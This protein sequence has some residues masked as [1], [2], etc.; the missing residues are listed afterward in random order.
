[1]KRSRTED[2]DASKQPRKK[3]RAIESGQQSSQGILFR[4]CHGQHILRNKSVIQAIVDKSGILPTDTVLEIG[5][6]T[7]ALTESLLVAAKKVV[8]IEIDERM[9]AELRKKFMKETQ[10]KKLQIIQGSCLDVDFPYFD[11]CVA[12]VPYNISSA[13]VF[14]LLQGSPKFHQPSDQGMPFKCA[15][16]MFQREFALRLVAQA[17]DAEY[18]RLSVNTQLLA[19]VSHLMKISRNSFV[20]PPK[21]ESSVVRIEL[22]RPAPAI[23]FKE[24]DELVK[25]LFTR[26]NRKISSI[27]SK[28]RLRARLYTQHVSHYNLSKRTPIEKEAFDASIGEILKREDFADQRPRSMPIDNFAWL[29]TAFHEKGIYFA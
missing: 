14:K 17:G 4:K 20:P 5:P 13:I 8:C 9:V 25:V 1:M 24:W 7:G 21:V 29:L 27:F 12:N 18:S 28:K 3:S 23:N 11:R 19:K 26:K 22:K 16:L 10:Q 6:G 15:I 2:Q